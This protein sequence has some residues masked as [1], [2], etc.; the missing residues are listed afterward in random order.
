MLKIGIVGCGKIADSHAA[1]IRRIDTCQL[2]GVCDAEPLMAEQLAERFSVGNY[3]TN[4]EQFLET[5]RPDVVHITTP[6][7]THLPI[8][9]A[10]LNHGAHILVEKPFALDTT[11]AQTL[12]DA[13]TRAG[14][15]VTVGHDGQFSAVARELRRLVHQ[16][17]LGGP[18]VHMESYWCYDLSDPTYAKALL[19]DTHHW[20]R[21]LPGGL[22]HNIID[23][24]VSKIAEFIESDAPQVLALGFVSPFL[25][26]L[27]CEDIFDELRVIVSEE[28]GTTA[29]FTFSTQMRPS[30]HQFSIYG[31]EQ[32]ITIDEDKRTL[33]TLNGTGFKSHAEHVLQ[34]LLYAKQYLG[35]SLTNMKRVLKREAHMDHGKYQL[36]RMFY[37]SVMELSPLPIPYREILLT[38]RI[39]DQIFAQ[40]SA[41]NAGQTR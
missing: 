1:Q 15:K 24:G 4:L 28:R 9:L 21:R 29:Y 34:P 14:R 18:P 41:G 36:F 17:F 25:R 30:L 7:H 33:I 35:N 19:N 12:I 40:V 39:M 13:A 37:D 5:D 16:G 6:P 27:G 38:S 3:Y 2:V 8:G 32:G 26:R 31:L 10:C 22:P 23:H 20:A 11:D